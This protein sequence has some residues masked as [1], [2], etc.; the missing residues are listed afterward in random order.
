MLPL[1]RAGGRLV[2]RPGSTFCLPLQMALGH[3]RLAR[4]CCSLHELVVL[5]VVVVVTQQPSLQRR[6]VAEQPQLVVLF[7]RVLGRVQVQVQV[8]G[9][10]QRQLAVWQT[11]ATL[12]L[13]LLL[14]L[15]SWMAMPR[16]GLPAP[17][18]LPLA[19]VAVLLQLLPA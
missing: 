9:Q 14:L 18:S 5:P 11:P 15:Q 13:L 12:L 10:G 19:P 6:P 1:R 7:P 8:Q 2:A 16:Q 3:S 4:P 17:R